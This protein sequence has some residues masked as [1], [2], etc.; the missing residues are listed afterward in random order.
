[1]T[2]NVINKLLIARRLLGLAKEHLLSSSEL[3]LGIGVNLLQ[4]AVEMFLLAISE[5]VNAEVE[6]NTKFDKYFELIN[7]RI[8][9]KE[10]PFRL[11]LIA[12]NKQRVSSKHYGI[13]PAR[14]EVEKMPVIVQEM[15][16]EVT[17]SVL[18]ASFG[19]VTLIDLL[20]EDEAKTVLK[21]AETAL[22]ALDFEGCLIAC[23]KAIFIRFENDYNISRFA[24]EGDTQQFLS[25]LLPGKHAPYYAKSKDYAQ[26]HVD[27]PTDYIVIDHN[28]LEMELMTSGVD[29][30][31]FWNIR[32]LTPAVYRGEDGEWQ[33]KREFSKLDP[34]GIKERA[35]YVLDTTINIFL[36]SQ[37]RMLA[38]RTSYGGLYYVNLLHECIPVYKKASLASEIVTTTPPGIKRLNVDS[39]SRALEGT[40]IF[41]HVHHYENETHIWGYIPNSAVDHTENVG[42]PNS[43]EAT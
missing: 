17:K 16:E 42:G 4:D 8:S 6:T 2:R 40:E 22:T 36:A 7:T 32:R 10:I 41:W 12:L 25:F 37:Q 15:F 9:P 20:R 35:E 26:R 31:S 1:M 5:H 34:E 13:I 14:S 33:V 11:P 23:R 27:E 24:K 30:V 28:K 29:S 3:A 21:G 39:E 18:S 19:S 38:T 43:G